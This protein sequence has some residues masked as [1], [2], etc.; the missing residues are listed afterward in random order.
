MN[1]GSTN[2]FEVNGTTPT[3]DVVVLGGTVTYGGVLKIV[4]TG[5]F[6]VGQTFRLFSGAGA[7][8]P[9]NFSS[10][11]GSP[12]SGK[13]FTFTNS[14]LTVVAAGPSGPA[15]LTNSYSGGVL[16]LSWPAGQGWRLQMQTNSLS[17]GLRRNWIYITD[18]TISSTN[19]AISPTQPAVFFRLTYP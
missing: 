15:R 7:T 12:G 14:V 10:L 19:I 18:G 17:V 16:S 3:N 1:P 11:Q 6:T 9:G 2:L 5:T 8:G 4:P 13:L